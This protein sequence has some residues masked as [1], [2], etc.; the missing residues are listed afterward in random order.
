[1]LFAR[2]F[3]LTSIEWSN[4]KS[5]LATFKKTPF[6]F[7]NKINP[8]LP[9]A[10]AFGTIYSQFPTQRTQRHKERKGEEKGFIY[11]IYSNFYHA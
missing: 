6:S 8:N 3:Q 4:P 10:G 1:M 2:L 7:P 11:L 9:L 5:Q